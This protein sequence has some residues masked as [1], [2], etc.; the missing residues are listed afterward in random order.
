[1]F[2]KVLWGLSPWVPRWLKDLFPERI[3]QLMRRQYLPRTV[4]IDIVGSCN[5]ACPSC[6][7]GGPD[8]NRGGKMSLEMFRRI[9]EKISKE[10]PGATVSIF[11]WTEPL[12]HPQAA[13]FVEAIRHY[14][15]K[16]RVSTNLNLLKDADRFAAAS[17]DFMTISLSGFT[18]PVYSVGHED[19]DIEVVKENMRKLSD[20]FKKAS[21]TTELTVYYH[22]YLHN[23]HEVDLMKQYAES[24]GFDFGS[25]WAYY[26][27]I[28]RVQAYMEDRLPPHEVEFV[29]NRFALNIRRAV[30]ATKP[31]RDEPCLFPTTQLTIDCRGNVQLCCAVYDANRFTI[32]SYL[33]SPWAE[34]E[35]KLLNHSY[36]RECGQHGLHVY[37]SWH[38]HKKI[39]PIYEAIAEEECRRHGTNPGDQP[40]QEPV[41]ARAH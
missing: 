18:Q 22:K 27:P 36:C 38:G 24:L 16:S 20:A 4:L 9:L 2:R 30:E 19:G 5:L 11:N 35:S 8:K 10:Q 40:A 3:K 41:R 32:G 39:H 14:G 33:D 13:E 25:G 28:E 23:L 29:E 1:M 26:M 7:S 12:I 21:A 6:P 15:L 31:F 37:T 34:I 17:P